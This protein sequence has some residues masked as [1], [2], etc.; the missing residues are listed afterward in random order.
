MVKRLLPLVGGAK[1]SAGTIA[2]ARH[3][4]L[5]HAPI[6]HAHPSGHRAPG[7]LG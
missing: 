5:I 7:A 1:E 6:P 4:R 2:C 3:V